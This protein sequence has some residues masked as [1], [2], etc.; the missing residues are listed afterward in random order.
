[1]SIH[2]I[3]ALDHV[4]DEY[5]NYRIRPMNYRVNPG[6]ADLGIQGSLSLRGERVRVRVGSGRAECYAKWMATGMGC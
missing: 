4:L 2:P 6:R 1:M 3:K 5:S